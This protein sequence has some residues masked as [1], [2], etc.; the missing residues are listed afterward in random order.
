M[1]DNNVNGSI[2]RWCFQI[3][4]CSS[5]EK[6]SRIEIVQTCRIFLTFTILASLSE[7]KPTTLQPY[8]ASADRI[9]SFASSAQ[10]SASLVTSPTS[11]ASWRKDFPGTWM[12]VAMIGSRW[13][14]DQPSWEM[15]TSFP[16]EWRKGKGGGSKALHI[17]KILRQLKETGKTNC[18]LEWFVHLP[19]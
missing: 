11:T 4:R 3:C 17:A 7:T 13:M 5:E 18:T 1:L 6:K 8:R 19:E 2:P 15:I 14:F 12:Q 16:W 9:D 10:Y